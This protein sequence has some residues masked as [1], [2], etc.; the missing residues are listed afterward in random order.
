[1]QLLKKIQIHMNN[2]LA[3]LQIALIKQTMLQK[4]EDEF[5]SFAERLVSVTSRYIKI[6]EETKTEKGKVSISL[7]VFRLLNLAVY[8]IYM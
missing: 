5:R 1:M 3:I 7:Y 8:I 4:Y 2:I 6:R